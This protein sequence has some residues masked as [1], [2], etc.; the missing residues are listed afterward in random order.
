MILV[1]FDTI[2]NKHIAFASNGVLSIKRKNSDIAFSKINKL[3]ALN[4]ASEILKWADAQPD[5][6]LSKPY[7]S[8]WDEECVPGN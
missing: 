4:L 8:D 3:Q 2:T 6:P 7:Y 5:D 1:E